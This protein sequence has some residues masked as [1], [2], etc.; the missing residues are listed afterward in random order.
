M[1]WL[2]VAQFAVQIMLTG[3]L[4]VVPACSGLVFSA[5]LTPLG[6]DLRPVQFN[7]RFPVH[8]DGIEMP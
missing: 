5:L 7:G 2:D 8:G 6:G 3:W 4:V 1:T